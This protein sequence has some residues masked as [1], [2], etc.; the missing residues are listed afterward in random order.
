MKK[1][2]FCA[3][4]SLLLLSSI[5]AAGIPMYI[6]VQGRVTNPDD[7][8]VA[9]AS[10]PFL[11][12][13]FTSETLC[14]GAGEIWTSGTQNVYVDKGVF[15]TNLNLTGSNIG[16]DRDYWLEVNF[17]G[18]ILCPRVRMTSSGYAFAAGRLY[19]T[20]NS[21][22]SGYNIT[23]VS[24]LCLGSDCKNAWPSGG[25]VT[26]VWVNETGDLMTGRLNI[27]AGVSPALY[28]KTTGTYA[29][30]FEGKLYSSNDIEAPRFV[31]SQNTAYYCDPAGTSVFNDLTVSG[32]DIQVGTDT[33]TKIDG[34]TVNQ[35]RLKADSYTCIDIG[36]GEKMCCSGAKCYTSPNTDLESGG[37]LMVLGTGN[38]YI[39]GSVGIGTPS[40]GNTLHVEKARSDT[41]SS[42]AAAYRLGGS[43]VYLFG[44][45][46]LSSPWSV[47]MQAFRPSDDATFPLVLNP[48]GGNVGI[49]TT[50][51]GAKL[52]V[53]SGLIETG[54]RSVKQGLSFV[55]SC[56]TTRVTSVHNGIWAP[57]YSTG[58]G[59]EWFVGVQDR[60]GGEAST[61]VIGMWNDA[62]DHIALMPS[63]NVGIGTTGPNNKLEVLST[64]YPQARISYDGDRYMTLSHSG[65]TANALA[66]QN[67]YLNI[68]MVGGQSYGSGVAGGILFRTNSGD[69]VFI[70]KSG[71]VGIGTTTPSGKLTIQ[72]PNNYDGQ[73]LRLESKAEPTVYNLYTENTVTGGV[74]RWG[75][76][77][78]NAGSA[79]PNM[80]VF[81]RGNV[82]IGT[83]SPGS[84]LDVRGITQI[85]DDGATPDTSSYASFGV[86]RANVA[87]NNA[88][89]G[90]TKQGVVPWGMG[91]DSSSSLIFGVSSASPARTI[92][93]PLLTVTTAGNVIVGKN[94][95]PVSWCNG[96]VGTQSNAFY[97]IWSVRQNF[98]AWDGTS[99]IQVDNLNHGLEYKWFGGNPGFRIQPDRLVWS[100][101]AASPS[102]D[103]NLYRSAANTLGTDSNL[104]VGGQ[105][106]ITG[107]SPGA[108]KV[109]TSDASGLATWQT[110]A[111]GLPTGTSG[112][113]LR[114]DGTNWVANSV[115]F[116]NGANV[117]IGTASP[118]GKLTVTGTSGDVRSVT[119]DNREIK[120]RGDGVA[121]FSI[122]GPDTGKRYL[123]IQN[124]GNNYLPGTAGT[125][126][127][128]ITPEG[129]VGVGT[130][131][132]KSILHV[133]QNDGAADTARAPII[134]SRYWGSD[135][136]T[137]ATAIYNYY[138]S[139]NANDQLVIGVTGGGGAYTNPAL[140]SNAKMVIQGNGNV[141]IGTT[142]P[143]YNLDV[144]G[145][146]RV[147]AGSNSLLFS[148]SWQGYPD[149]ATNRAEISNDVGSYKTLMIVG[150]KANDGS[151]RR[152]SVWD[153]LEVNGNAAVT[154][155]LY[156]DG[157]VGRTGALT[158]MPNSA[159]YFVQVGYGGTPRD[160]YVWGNLNI[161]NS[162]G[163]KKILKG[164]ATL[165]GIPCAVDYN[166]FRC[167]DWNPGVTLSTD[168][169]KTM[170]TVSCHERATGSNQDPGDA[171]LWGSSAYVKNSNTI[172]G[173]CSCGMNIGSTTVNAYADILYVEFA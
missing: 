161:G 58:C 157:I 138:N 139:A 9:S 119:I 164:E 152:V 43:D 151:T 28:V 90:L 166:F 42:A 32:G 89:I 102:W 36:G 135:S 81:D 160:L 143:G 121:H 21:N 73:T 30:Q 103:T 88:Y 13:I 144:N 146:T 110:S 29:G 134:M 16:F 54:T 141:G 20:G 105:I 34:N 25:A 93:T 74:V 69:R 159:S 64:T 111:G 98:E 155:N 50:N 95:Y 114:H 45:S 8:P 84:K 148:S 153:R 126:L 2:V 6:T 15:S 61:L 123:T 17:N 171:T 76:S 71:N 80:L 60:D 170:V 72:T 140:Y 96:D 168:A 91:I 128:T 154:G 115:I 23:N 169:S 109:L 124:T 122:F 70:D 79:Y 162:R 142:S 22:M 12:K 101:R 117:G 87:Q 137:R 59:D 75:F 163:I 131:N 5:V 35:L 40:P 118:S 125:D 3:I 33:G 41:I 68:E 47:W 106:K 26:D 27:T 18:N 112:Q 99:W 85:T 130:T 11:F 49:G 108:G 120:F 86:T 92:P 100:D 56:G 149:G 132:P 63:G 7:S 55:D 66:A 165:S 107:G 53:A 10:Y 48:N 1:L 52:H 172:K 127:L 46:K 133:A 77:M 145:M 97:S 136:D 19:A 116:N 62:N 78:T 4:A 147:N 129:Y 14:G 113:T 83:A 82:G 150:N 31:D 39:M 156:T 158:L 104:N 57:D 38:S 173:C 67:N 51:P 37:E 94:V 65:I 44:G 24:Y 167:F